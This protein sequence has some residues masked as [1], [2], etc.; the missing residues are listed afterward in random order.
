MADA[1]L[2]ALRAIANGTPD[3][4]IKADPAQEIARIDLIAMEAIA[5]HEAAQAEA[6]PDD[7]VRDGVLFRF[8]I[9]AASY[10]GGWP[11]LL[12]ATIQ[13]ETMAEG[14]ATPAAYRRALIAVAKAKG[15][16]LP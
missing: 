1:L 4:P 3:N 14:H 2:S 5:A 13:K 10:P 11:S 6:D 16:N 7:D 9:R 12:A 15:V 8:W